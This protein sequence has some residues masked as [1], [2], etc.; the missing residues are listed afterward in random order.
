MD[1]VSY[2]TLSHHRIWVWSLVLSILAFSCL[3]L[4]GCFQLIY[5]TNTPVEKKLN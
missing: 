1:Q 4:A 2:I 3:F 5:W